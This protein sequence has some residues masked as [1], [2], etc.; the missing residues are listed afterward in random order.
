MT[1]R[2]SRSTPLGHFAERYWVESRQPLASLIFIAPLLGVYEAGV[3]AFG[4]NA[5]RNGA[6]AWMR[7]MLEQLGFSQYYLLPGW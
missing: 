6:D 2:L 5:G 4:R 3:L 7:Q 1:A